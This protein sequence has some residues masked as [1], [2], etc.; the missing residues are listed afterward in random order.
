MGRPPHQPKSAPGRLSAST[1]DET[2]SAT[3]STS[4]PKPAKNFKQPTNS[5]QQPSIPEGF[6]AEPTANG[7]GT[8][9]RVPGTD[10]N[11]GTIRVM[12]P[13]KQYPNGYWRKY[14]KHGQP[15]NPATGKP[16]S[17]AETHIPLPGKD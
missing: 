16:G 10:G 13:T 11:A 6:V 2:V 3:S 1:A 4:A 17:K 9:Y 8:V 15:V 5:A 7:R 12:G 14:N